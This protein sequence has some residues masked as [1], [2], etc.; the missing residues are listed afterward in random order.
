MQEKLNQRAEL[1]NRWAKGMDVVFPYYPFNESPI[2]EFDIFEWEERRK[3]LIYCK[4]CRA[5]KLIFD[6][7]LCGF[8]NE[9]RRVEMVRRSQQVFKKRA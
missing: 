9:D 1:T 8:C 3:E 6:N 7:G 2:H 4:S 5:R